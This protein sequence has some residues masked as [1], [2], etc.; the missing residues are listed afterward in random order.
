VGDALVLAAG[1]IVVGLLALAG[2]LALVRV[3][4]K[5]A[6]NE[7]RLSEVEAYDHTYNNL[8]TDYDRV[9]AERAA[10]KVTLDT[11]TADRDDWR[12]RALRA[13][14]QVEDWLPHNKEQ[15]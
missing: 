14:R 2:T 3:Q 1:S 7:E 15:P 12:R 9:L 5:A 8:R 6:K 13:E 4:R 10:M 11:I